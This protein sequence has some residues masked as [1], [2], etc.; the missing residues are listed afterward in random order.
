ME[1][2]EIE[3]KLMIDVPEHA[4]FAIQKKEIPT[5]DGK[6]T[7]INS[8]R[9]ITPTYREAFIQMIKTFKDTT[10]EAYVYRGA[11]QSPQIRA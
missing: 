9:N 8:F 5:W 7:I 4:P 10:R 11:S 6:T 3:R 2:S 1:L